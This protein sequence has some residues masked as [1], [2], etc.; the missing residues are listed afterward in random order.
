MQVH[1]PPYTSQSCPTEFDELHA[2]ACVETK[3]SSASC[4]ADSMQKSLDDGF[5]GLHR[6]LY[7]HINGSGSS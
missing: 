3:Q 1:C 2:Q 4:V 5:T 7:W 6:V